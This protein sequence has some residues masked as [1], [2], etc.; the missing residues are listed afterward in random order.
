MF[1]MSDGSTDST[2]QTSGIRRC[3]FSSSIDFQR[4][5]LLDSA[6][7][8]TIKGLMN[9]AEQKASLVYEWFLIIT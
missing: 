1:E 6:S 7:V 8:H 5:V 9:K 2:Q 4:A 3:A